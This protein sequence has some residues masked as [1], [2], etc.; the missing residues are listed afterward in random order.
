MVKSDPEIPAPS[1]EVLEMKV[2]TR[3]PV[4]YRD[5]ILMPMK[6]SR[7]KRY[8]ASGLGKI[9]YNSD[10]FWLELNQPPSDNDMQEVDAQFVDPKD[11]SNTKRC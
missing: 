1:L 7:V 6:I 9:C 10:Q 5:M 8:V 3:T 11:H 4:R 2:E